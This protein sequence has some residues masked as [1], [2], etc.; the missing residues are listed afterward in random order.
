[1]PLSPYTRNTTTLC[2]SCQVFS[3]NYFLHCVYLSILSSLLFNP[4]IKNKLL[5]YCLYIKILVRLGFYPQRKNTWYTCSMDIRN[6]IKELR[7]SKGL[8]QKEFARKI[9]VSVQTVSA[10]EIGLRTPNAIQRR[11]LCGIFNISE[12]ELFGGPL[13]SKGINPEV[14]SALQDPLAVK[15]LLLTYKNSPDIKNT[16][17]SLVEC[18]PNLSPEK[19]QA[20]LIL[21]K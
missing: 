14:L 19:R 13:S 3:Y 7:E 5:F 6:R 1:M 16:I 11:K 15:I 20:L 9:N 10:W 8:I 18:L 2:N 21:C 12:A 17:K 4:A